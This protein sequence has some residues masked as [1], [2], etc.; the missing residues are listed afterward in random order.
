MKKILKCVAM[1]VPWCLVLV[2]LITPVPSVKLNNL[3]RGGEFYSLQ[4]NGSAENY[5]YDI[6]ELVEQ[7]GDPDLSNLETAEKHEVTDEDVVEEIN[8]ELSNYT[9]K[10]ELQNGMTVESGMN[11]NIDYAGIVVDAVVDGINGTSQD[12]A[13][14][15]DVIMEG[16]D[17]EIEGHSVGE[18]FDVSLD[19][20]ESFNE[21]LAG[22]TV[23]FSITINSASVDTEVS[24]DSVTDEFVKKNI[25]GY[26]TVE[27]YKAGMRKEVEEYFDLEF[28]NG[29]KIAVLTAL[30]DVCKVSIP[31]ELLD[32]ETEIY[33]QQFTNMYCKD[34]TLEEY[35]S[36]YYD[37]SLEDF[38]DTIKDDVKTSIE[39]V[40]VCQYFAN[41]LK[42]KVTD[43]YLK[44]Y[45]DE[46]ATGTSYSSEN[47]DE[48]YDMYKTDYMCGREYLERMALCD[49]VVEHF[50]D[51]AVFSYT[52]ESAEDSD[53]AI[54]EED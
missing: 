28:E 27:G 1:I 4:K 45:I 2:L 20:P 25:S 39:N 42:I 8:N 16:L 30:K 50:M 3:I 36:T 7:T 51:G 19:I 6:T 11:A 37:T 12:I 9:D 32:Q 15:S 21:T 38:Y 10:T 33:A 5:K 13:L 31:D 22:K 46:L 34:Q 47:M 17:A 54:T 49:M 24:L 44:D 14:G 35:L 40:L 52:D 53:G 41:K 48:I 29:K 43:E 26:D 18:T 23:K